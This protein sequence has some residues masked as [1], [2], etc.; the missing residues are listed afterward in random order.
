MT[1]LGIQVN[2]DFAR[3]FFEAK[4]IISQLAREAAALRKVAPSMGNHGGGFPS[5][6]TNDIGNQKSNSENL[7]NGSLDIS[8]CF[9]RLQIEL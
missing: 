9:A 5:R 7:E 8:I 3:S 6:T 4:T 2:E 1:G